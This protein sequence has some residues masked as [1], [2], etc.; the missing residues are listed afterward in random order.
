MGVSFFF[1]PLL[2]VSSLS[3]WDFF[4]GGCWLGFDHEVGRSAGFVLED[5]R[6]IWITVVAYSVRS[7]AREKRI[8]SFLSVYVE[9]KG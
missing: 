9:I 7:A 6:M 8:S 3:F 1:S 5:H 4:W 2:S